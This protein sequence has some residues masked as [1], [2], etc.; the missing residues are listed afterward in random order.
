MMRCAVVIRWLVPMVGRKIRTIYSHA[1]VQFVVTMV[2]V[3]VDNWKVQQSSENVWKVKCALL[4][5]QISRNFPLTRMSRWIGKCGVTRVNWSIFWSR[6]VLVQQIQRVMW[7][8][9]V[10]GHWSA[11]LYNRYTVFY[12]WSVGL[13]ARRTQVIWKDR[14]SQIVEVFSWKDNLLEFLFLVYHKKIFKKVTI[15]TGY[16]W[17]FNFRTFCLIIQLKL[18]FILVTSQMGDHWLFK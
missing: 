2:V 13:V 14:V 16:F 18:Y 5:F 10:Y 8:C 6:R 11:L 15:F 9:M 7:F 1:D 3:D 4:L 12:D 17:L